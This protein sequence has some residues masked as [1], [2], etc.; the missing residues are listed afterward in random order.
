M[1]RIINIKYIF[2]TWCSKKCL[3]KEPE[4]EKQIFLNLN[5]MKDFEK[6]W[7]IEY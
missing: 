2:I 1:N 4:L 3:F 6:L 7:H 5:I